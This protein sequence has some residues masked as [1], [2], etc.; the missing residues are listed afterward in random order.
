MSLAAM[1]H[2][3]E[4]TRLISTTISRSLW[5][6]VVKR[7]W[8]HNEPGFVWRDRAITFEMMLDAAIQTKRMTWEDAERIT[9]V[10]TDELR[11]RLSYSLR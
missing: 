10:R 3:A 6:E 11:Q 5:S 1:I 9:G 7:G 8:Q 2:M 4:K